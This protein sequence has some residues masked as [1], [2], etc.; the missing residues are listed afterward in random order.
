MEFIHIS[1]WVNCVRQFAY[2]NDQGGVTN[3]QIYSR[4]FNDY[5]TFPVAFTRP[6]IVTCTNIAETL[7][8]DSWTTS[9][10]SEVKMEK[11]RYQS[12]QNGVTRLQWHAI[13]K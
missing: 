4:A 9:A 5:I 2:L 6:P 3:I 10:I 12:A 7:D 8:S 11:F 1:P 13:G